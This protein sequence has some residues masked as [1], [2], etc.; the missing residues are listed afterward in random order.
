M[1]SQ[2]LRKSDP[3]KARDQEQQW[4]DRN[5]EYVRVKQRADWRKRQGI[6]LSDSDLDYM[7]HIQERKCAICRVEIC[8]VPDHDHDTHQLRE[9][10]CNKCNLVLGLVGDNEDILAAA[11]EYL[12]EHRRIREIVKW[13]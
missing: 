3:Q 6:A 10:L 8:L 1:A 13:D 2:K 12:Q 11:L 9:L 5:R 7:R 4:R